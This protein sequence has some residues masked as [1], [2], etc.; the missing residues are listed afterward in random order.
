MSTGFMGPPLAANLP[1]GQPGE[2]VTGHEPASGVELLHF[3][4]R[5]CASSSY[6]ELEHRFVAGFGRLFGLPM[7][8]LYITDPCTGRQQCLAPTG[9]SDSFRA[10]YERVG[11]E[12]NWLQARL[13][14]TG[15][16]VY[17]MA[18]MASMD[19]WLENPLYTRLMYLHDIRHKVQAPIVSGDGV[20][21]TLHCST[22]D[23][24]RGFTPYEVQLTEALGRVVGTV[25]EGIYSRGSLERERDQAVVALD[26]TGTAVVITDLADPEPRLNDAARRLL[27]EVVDAECAL[28]RVIVRPGA[29]GGFSRYVDVELAD[30]GTGLLR[31]HSSYTRAEGSAPITRAEG[32]MITVLELQ[33]DRSEISADTLTALTPR[34]REV[35]LFVVDG[36]SDREIAERLSLS[37]HT[38]SQYVKR[39]YRKLDVPSRVALTRLLL[40]LRDSSS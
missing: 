39:I 33:R 2:Q 21:G 10:R 35:A 1:E 18:L 4:Q 19:E 20:I 16:P 28:H 14:A 40:D 8:A 7:H 6:A 23:P 31:G 32:A 29:D 11:Q 5:L 38:V 17:N 36:R 25:I 34:E 24:R 13:D 27:A 30:G 22:S 26:R 9:I 12:L 37:R 3:T 15:R